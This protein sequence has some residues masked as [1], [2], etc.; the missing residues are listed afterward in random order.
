MSV[1]AT[2]F[3]FSAGFGSGGAA[4]VVFFGVIWIELRYD[5]RLEQQ[6]ILSE[7]LV[8]RHSMKITNAKKRAM[9]MK[10]GIKEI[11]VY[12]LYASGSTS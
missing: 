6:P 3:G 10:S 9:K 11:M 1:L 4:D 5:V 7:P 8:E 2:S 12:F